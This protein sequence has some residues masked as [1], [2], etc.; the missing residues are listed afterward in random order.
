MRV[1]DA[2]QSV[3]HLLQRDPVCYVIVRFA[4]ACAFFTFFVYR[5]ISAANV[6]GEQLR[7]A[8]NVGSK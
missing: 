5:G 4:C 7:I 1:I 8:R 3:N 2:P 6:D